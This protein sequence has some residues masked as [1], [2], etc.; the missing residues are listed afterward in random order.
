[1]G[2]FE[3]VVNFWE[4]EV[5]DKSSSS[6]E[7]VFE[8]SSDVQRSLYKSYLVE[9]YFHTTHN[10]FSQVKAASNFPKDNHGLFKKFVMHALAET[11]HNFLALDDFEN[12]GGDKNFV[13]KN[14]PLKTTQD[15]IDYTYECADDPSP[16][17]YL[18]YLFHVEYTP[19]R[20][21]PKYVELLTARVGAGDFYSFLE[22]HIEVDVQHQKMLKAYFD[23]LVR[24]DAELELVKSSLLVAAEKFND[25]LKGSFS[26]PIQ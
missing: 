10:P 4:E 12:I 5:F 24:T 9:T 21:G 13:G 14:P 22:E 15:L 7:R 25:F 23:N 26:R 17:R 3:G 19:T 1:M 2:V 16:L 18:A 11:G 6:L 20:I 8:L